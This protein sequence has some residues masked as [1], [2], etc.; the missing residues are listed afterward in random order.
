MAQRVIKVSKAI[1]H[2]M[3]E[4]GNISQHMEADEALQTFSNCMCDCCNVKTTT[5]MNYTTE[6]FFGFLYTLARHVIEIVKGKGLAYTSESIGDEENPGTFS[7]SDAR[8][9]GF[10]NFDQALT[11]LQENGAGVADASE[12]ALRNRISQISTLHSLASALQYIYDHRTYIKLWAQ[13]STTFPILGDGFWTCLLENGSNEVYTHVNQYMHTYGIYEVVVY[14]YFAKGAAAIPVLASAIANSDFIYEFID[15]NFFNY[16]ATTLRCHLDSLN[17][18]LIENCENKNPIFKIASNM[19]DDM[20]KFICTRNI[21]SSPIEWKIA[22]EAYYIITRL[23]LILIPDPNGGK[24]SI[25][26]DSATMN[27]LKQTVDRIYDSSNTSSSSGSSG[28]SSDGY[29]DSAGISTE[30][31]YIDGAIAQNFRDY[32]KEFKKYVEI[33]L[34]RNN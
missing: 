21:C 5:A 11:T 13:D 27:L 10:T 34:G 26:N 28:A 8:F 12:A 17:R 25:S 14:L 24:I 31:T 20:E 30:Y 3:I 7:I 32:V 2:A 6:T 19:I 4:M 29:L 23:R 15:A 33:M 22:A 18:E 1:Q 9:N 16:S